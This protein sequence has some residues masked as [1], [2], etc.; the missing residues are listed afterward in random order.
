[1]VHVVA[2][3]IE[4]LSPMLD[5]LL[6]LRSA[7]TG[8]GRATSRE[9]QGPKFLKQGICQISS[10]RNLAARMSRRRACQKSVNCLIR[11]TAPQSAG[12]RRGGRAATST[13]ARRPFASLIRSSRSCRRTTFCCPLR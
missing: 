6:T 8:F 2:E 5:R 10:L 13:C 1:V 3:L 11:S 9:G 4:D 12:R 7:M